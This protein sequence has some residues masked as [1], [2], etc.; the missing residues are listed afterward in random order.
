VD[1]GGIIKI[2]N[3]KKIH[4]STATFRRLSQP[5]I[6]LKEQIV[7]PPFLSK[8]AKFFVTERTFVESV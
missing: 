2:K 1:C 6:Q 4:K 7:I 8:V 5:T 3:M